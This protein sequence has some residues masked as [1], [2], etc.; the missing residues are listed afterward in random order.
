MPEGLGTLARRRAA[1]LDDGADHRHLRPDGSVT[2]LGTGGSNRIRTAILQVAV[3]LLDHGMS[4]EDAVDGAAAASG[5]MRHVQLRARLLGGGASGFS[6]A[7]R[8]AHAWPDL[9]SRSSA[10]CIRR[11]DTRM[12]ASKAPATR[13]AAGV[14]VVRMRWR[15]M[16]ESRRHQPSLLRGRRHARRRARRAR[17]RACA[18]CKPASTIC[19]RRGAPTSWSCSAARSAYMSSTAIRFSRQSSP[20]SRR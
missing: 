10:A 5:E 18:I 16:K 13:A 12:A 14:A 9:K 19:R 7:S 15:R 11:A 3:N 17:H 8:K 2:A 20:P 6:R 4:L 1:V